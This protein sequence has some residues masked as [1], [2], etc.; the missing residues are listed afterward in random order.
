[1]QSKEILIESE[2]FPFPGLKKFFL[3]TK[4]I[5]VFYSLISSHIKDSESSKL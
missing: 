4:I 3:Q 1:M 5:L 2:M